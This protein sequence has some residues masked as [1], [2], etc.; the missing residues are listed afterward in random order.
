MLRSDRPPS[1]PV[2][3]V[4]ESLITVEVS[5]VGERDGVDRGRW[6]YRCDGGTDGEYGGP[7]EWT[8]STVPGTVMS[9][10]QRFQT[11]CSG[12]NRSNYISGSSGSGGH[13]DGV[14]YRS[15]TSQSVWFNINQNNKTVASFKTPRVFPTRVVSMSCLSLRPDPSC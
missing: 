11:Y 10:S 7:V 2:S 12:C 3:R 1:P 4:R 13:H 8:K 5:G 14:Y 9:H 6:V 15:L